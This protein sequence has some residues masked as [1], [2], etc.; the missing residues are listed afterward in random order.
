MIGTNAQ[1]LATISEQCMVIF[2]VQ[3]VLIAKNVPLSQLS[4]VLK[5]YR[6]E[7]T[8]VGSISNEQILNEHI[9]IQLFAKMK[10]KTF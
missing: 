2:L 7:I 3:Q 4:Q 1:P 5:I 10:K 6:L 8:L 9:M